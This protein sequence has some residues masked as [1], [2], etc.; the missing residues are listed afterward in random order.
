M[1]GRRN[2]AVSRN[3]IAVYGRPLA[4]RARI[5]ASLICGSGTPAMWSRSVT[6]GGEA[7]R[8]LDRSSRDGG[9]RVST[10]SHVATPVGAGVTG[11]GFPS[12]GEDAG[13]R[14]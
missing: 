7:R 3:S 11:G 14:R 1:S 5:V 12:A 8:S 9:H 4:I 2:L 6:P 10:A 13:C